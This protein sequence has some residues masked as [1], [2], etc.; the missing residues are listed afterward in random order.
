[1]AGSN[2]LLP[3]VTLRNQLG[4]MRNPTQWSWATSAL[5][6]AATWLPGLGKESHIRWGLCLS[7][8]R[9]TL[10]SCRFHC[11]PLHPLAR[12][13]PASLPCTPPLMATSPPFLMPK[14]LHQGQEEEQQMK[15]GGANQFPRQVQ[16]Q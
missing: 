2:S 15:V 14:A 5:L 8:T 13:S 11:F 9:S 16:Q 6:P 4:A 7:L 12:T 10:R 1:M 3:H